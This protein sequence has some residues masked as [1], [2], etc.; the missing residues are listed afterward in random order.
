MS[1]TIE[2][3]VFGNKDM[4]SLKDAIAAAARAN[5][6]MF[7][8]TSDQGSLTKEHCYPGDFD[9]CIRIGGAT[10]TGEA[11]TWVNSDKVHFL[12]PGHNVPFV[13]NE[14]HVMSSESG[15]SV[16]TAAASGL[17]GLLMYSSWILGY[18]EEYL[19]DNKNMCE[20]IKAI[21]T[22]KMF[23]KV[24]QYFDERF[25][26]ELLRTE[27]PGSRQRQKQPSLGCSLSTMVWNE[28]CDEALKRV[29][30]P[31]LEQH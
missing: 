31:I 12:L 16:A 24:Q 1:W 3:P 2:T 19:R 28:N 22:A 6:I 17:A 4:E 25:K 8:S 11:L 15:S 14:G 21:S 30:K 5:I 20:A 18:G 26:Q 10:D 23:P 9:G 7:C 29:L 27:G 13:N